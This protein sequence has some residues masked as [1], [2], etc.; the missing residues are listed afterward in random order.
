MVGSFTAIGGNGSC[1]FRRNNDGHFIPYVV[2][3]ELLYKHFQVLVEFCELWCKGLLH[4]EV[5]ICEEE[6]IVMMRILYKL[7]LL[8]W[9]DLLSPGQ[10]D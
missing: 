2:S 3:F 7:E 9:I 10:K 1:K 8:R 6:I 5:M 4:V